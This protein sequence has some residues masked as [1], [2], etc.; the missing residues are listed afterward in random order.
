MAM[1]FN[2]CGE[3]LAKYLYSQSDLP[4]SFATPSKARE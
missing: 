4:P 3:Q 2:N 1:T